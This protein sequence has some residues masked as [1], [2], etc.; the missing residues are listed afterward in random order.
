MKRCKYFGCTSPGHWVLN[1]SPKVYLTL[2]DAH[3]IT[4][5]R[6]FKSGMVTKCNTMKFPRLRTWIKKYGPFIEVE[7]RKDLDPYPTNRILSI[8]TTD[9]GKNS[10][11][12]PGIIRV[13]NVE[14]YLVSTKPMP[15]P[16][17]NINVVGIS[18]AL[19]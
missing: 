10:Y 16:E 2:C 18:Q 7:N 17:E 4:K 3:L 12:D 1:H 11:G 8:C 14:T 9:N 13:Y 15:G 19:G 6:E 5:L